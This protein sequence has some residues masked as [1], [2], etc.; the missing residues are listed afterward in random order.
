MMLIKI[1]K[2]GNKLLPNLLN[3]LKCFVKKSSNM[4]NTPNIYSP[5]SHGGG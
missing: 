5:N 1:C 4:R 2:K 3:I